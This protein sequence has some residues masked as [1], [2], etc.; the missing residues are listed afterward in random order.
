MKVD[1]HVELGTWRWWEGQCAPL[2]ALAASLATAG[3]SSGSAAMH[4]P[5]RDTRQT[6]AHPQRQS[7]DEFYS[8]SA[9]MP[10]ARC[11]RIAR[12]P[13]RALRQARTWRGAGSA[14]QCA[15]PPRRLDAPGITRLRE[16]C[17]NRAPAGGQRVGS[18][19]AAEPGCTA[20]KVLTPHNHTC[21]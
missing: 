12:G 11:S 18:C 7:D 8:L 17:A 14:R 13:G 21:D 2:L 3:C 16:I 19:A 4:T 1:R 15:K 5:A 9:L 6:T 10:S 20:Y